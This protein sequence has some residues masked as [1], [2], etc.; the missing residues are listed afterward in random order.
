MPQ[1]RWTV[2]SLHSLHREI[3]TLPYRQCTHLTAA[4]HLKY[5][6]RNR[7]IMY[8]TCE[9]L[10]R[11]VDCRFMKVLSRLPCYSPPELRLIC[12]LYFATT[13]VLRA[14]CLLLT[15][16]AAAHSPQQSCQLPV[17]ALTLSIHHRPFTTK[18][19]HLTRHLFHILSSAFQNLIFNIIV[20]VM[21]DSLKKM[22]ESVLDSFCVSFLY[23]HNW[24]VLSLCVFWNLQNEV[25][26][27]GLVQW[28]IPSTFFFFF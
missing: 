12:A 4:S 20:N 11:E 21:S 27:D 17:Q 8:W 25:N 16:R 28:N 7:N 3:F 19:G 23:N 10:Y 9:I 22:Q 5:T 18:W 14:N 13:P 24:P 1:I 6:K 2:Q 26:K 15:D